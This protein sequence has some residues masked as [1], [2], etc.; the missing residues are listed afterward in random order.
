MRKEPR[1]LSDF[2]FGFTFAILVAVVWSIIF[3][4]V[5]KPGVIPALIWLA[6]YAA[7][8]LR[9]NLSYS[10]GYLRPVITGI[11]W[12]IILGASLYFLNSF[13]HSPFWWAAGSYFFGFL[14]AGYI[15]Y[16]HLLGIEA[17]ADAKIRRYHFVSLSISIAAYLLSLLWLH[18]VMKW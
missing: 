7:P 15:S 5:W 4:F 16:G 10:R 1:Q 13:G 2:A 8:H 9:K 12:G 18:T 17:L 14:A 3:Y 11:A 6:W